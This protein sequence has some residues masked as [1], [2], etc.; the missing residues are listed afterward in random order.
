MYSELKINPIRVFVSLGC[1]ADERANPQE[2]QIGLNLKFASPPVGCSTD[3]IK[4]TICYRDLAETIYGI[5]KS[6]EFRL[7]EHLAHKVFISL[8]EKYPEVKM[9]LDAKKVHP[10]HE[11][12][13]GGLNFIYG[14]L[15]Y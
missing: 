5:A 3:D 15:E 11:L 12:L 10:P 8:K 2:V 4:D 6:Q 1:G 7:I 13:A 14:D 9:R